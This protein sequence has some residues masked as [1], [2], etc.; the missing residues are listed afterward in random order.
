MKPLKYY[1]TRGAEGFFYNY[2]I[3]IFILYINIYINFCIYRL[4]FGLGMTF[5]MLVLWTFCNIMC[6]SIKFCLCLL[7]KPLEHHNRNVWCLSRGLR[8][9][10]L[11]WAPIMPR[12][13]GLSNNH[14]T[15]LAETQSIYIYISLWNIKN[16][17]IDVYI[18]IFKLNWFSN[19]WK[20]I[21]IRIINY[22]PLK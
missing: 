19:G 11:N 9:G 4:T 10:S 16:I 2:K 3:C 18:Y 6:L 1:T 7:Y 5:T 17:C 21:F 14:A 15:N 13:V 8:V 12:G 20:N 22:N